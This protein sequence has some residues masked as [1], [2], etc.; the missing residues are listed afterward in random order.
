MEGICALEAYLSLCSNLDIGKYRVDSAV[1]ASYKRI[2]DEFMLHPPSILGG[3]GCDTNSTDVDPPTASAMLASANTR[4]RAHVGGR[5]AGRTMSHMC[6]HT[7]KALVR[8]C[9]A[10]GE[11]IVR[12]PCLS[13][14]LFSD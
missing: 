3:R 4:T 2:E 6:T 8:N 14:E 13:V 10:G 12:D 1:V 11:I 9:N 5:T 7:L